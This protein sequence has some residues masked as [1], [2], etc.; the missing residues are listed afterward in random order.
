MA[1][2]RLSG[3]TTS[4]SVP[5]NG[6]DHSGGGDGGGG[7]AGGYVDDVF[8]TY[9]YEGDGTT[10]RTIENG[11]NLLD[12]GGLVWVKGRG[13][14]TSHMLQDTERGPTMTLSS[15]NTSESIASQH[16]SAFETNGFTTSQYASINSSGED[17]TSWTFRKARSFFDVVTWTGNGVP[18]REIPHNLGCQPGMVIV[19]Q[20]SGDRDWAVNHIGIDGSLEWLSLNQDM[21]STARNDIFGQDLNNAGTESFK[22]GDAPWCNGITSEYVAYVFA[23]DDSE[24]GMIQCGTYTGNGSD[25]GPEIDLGWEPQWVLIKCSSHSHRW[26]ILDNMRGIVTGKNDP[27]LSPDLSD[28]EQSAVPYMDLKAT[29]FKLTKGNS[30]YSNLLGQEY[31]YMA[32]RRPNKPASEFEPEELFAVAPNADGSPGYISGFPVDMG[33]HRKPDSGGFTSITS[34]L[35]SFLMYTNNDDA[36]APTGASFDYQDGWGSSA[37]AASQAWMWRRQPGFFDVVCYEGDKVAGREIP[38]NLGAVPEMMWVKKINASGNWPVWHK[39]LPLNYSLYLHLNI[40]KGNY[41]HWNNTTPTDTEF[42]VG[43]PPDI[44]GSGDSYIAYLFASVPGICDIGTYTGNS[45]FVDVDCGFTNGARF[46]LIKRTDGNGDWMYFDTVRGISDI[47]Q[48]Y[49]QSPMLKLNSTDAQ[50]ADREFISPTS[51]G[52]RALLADTTLIDGAEYIYMA[53]A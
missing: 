16:L 28:A 21:A 10:Y 7:S 35:I 32:I 38:H 22:V 51:E 34:R 6:G 52:F 36:G 20:V 42:T 49:P 25:D 47:S 3:M 53:I 8:S 17:Y 30:S 50:V 5:D 19:K 15:N 40:P 26:I 24:G 2:R 41:L 39:S 27:T 33:F 44:N 12:E 18:G 46:V 13:L 43:T 4:S 9:L 1:T 31:I 11:I 45:T 23:H 37:R 14:T 48:G 29:G